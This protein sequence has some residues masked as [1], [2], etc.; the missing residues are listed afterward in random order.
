MALAQRCGRPHRANDELAYHV[1]DIMCAVAGSAER[2]QVIDLKSTCQ[3][4][5]PFTNFD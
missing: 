4:P 2:G 5:A 1:L 3:R